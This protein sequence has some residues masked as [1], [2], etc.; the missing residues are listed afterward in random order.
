MPDY[1]VWLISM[2]YILSAILLHS[3][4]VHGQSF[5]G[6]INISISLKNLFR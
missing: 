4:S 2:P 6:M 3:M 1:V 5:F